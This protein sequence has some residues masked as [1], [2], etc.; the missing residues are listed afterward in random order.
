MY[1]KWQKMDGHDLLGM[2]NSSKRRGRKLKNGGGRETNYC[3]CPQGAKTRKKGGEGVTLSAV[4]NG[5]M[6]RNNTY[7]YIYKKWQKMM[8]TIY[9][10]RINQVSNV[11]GN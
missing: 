3:K 6:I 2:D 11:A 1:K 5:R 9:G 4:S 8:D 10:R 7:E